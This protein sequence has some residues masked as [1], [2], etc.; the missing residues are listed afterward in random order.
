M[1]R[2]TV[3]NANTIISTSTTT[4]ACIVC[5]GVGIA[6]NL[7]VGGVLTGASSFS[8]GIDPHEILAARLEEGTLE[9]GIDGKKMADKS[10]QRQKW[11]MIGMPE[12]GPML[13]KR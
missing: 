11:S 4:G 9:A 1:V 8:D 10:P 2:L 12:K 7:N 6:R 13:E 3:G 5:G